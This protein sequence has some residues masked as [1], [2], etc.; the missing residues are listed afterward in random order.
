MRLRP[1][2][3][4]M[5]EFFRT[6]NRE[7]DSCD[8]LEVF[9]R[10]VVPLCGNGQVPADEIIS[11]LFGEV[12]ELAGRGFIG[13]HGR[14]GA[15]EDELFRVILYHRELLSAHKGFM[16]MVF[17]ALFNINV[18]NERSMKR[19]SDSMLTGPRA[20]NP[21]VFKKLGFVH[22]WMCGL[23]RYRDEALA[24]AGSFSDD[25]LDSILGTAQMR[26]MD[27]LS[28]YKDDPWFYPGH[29]AAGPVYLYADGHRALGGN[30]VDI[31][32][33]YARDGII[34]AE[35]PQSVFRIY[36]DFFGADIVHEP[37]AV[38]GCGRNSVSGNISFAGGKIITGE[39]EFA[40]PRFCSGDVKSMA[41]AG[42][43]IA[44]TMKN[45]YKVYIAG[46]RTVHD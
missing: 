5:Y 38:P 26:G 8:I 32:V 35:D 13:R 40:L 44:W 43:T 31:P 30:F 17:N 1:E 29:A 45:S 16:T 19:W 33:V 24:V 25:L 18:K 14:S 21:A 34:Y 42:N 20:D 39:A 3:N 6:V 22:A 41:S 46:L 7:P 4:S 27:A 11:G 2:L 37:E 15:V 36:A 9:C 23:S 12:L 10:T 28:L